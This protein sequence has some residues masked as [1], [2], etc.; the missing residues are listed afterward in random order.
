MIAIKRILAL[1]DCSEPSSDALLYAMEIAKNFKADLIVLKVFSTP[2]ETIQDG[3]VIRDYNVDKKRPEQVREIEDFWNRFAENGIKPE[4]VNL[5]G[6]PFDKIIEYSQKHSIDMIVMGTHG[7]T[8]FKHIF[9]GSVAEKVV[10]YSS[11]P[12]LTVKQKDFEYRQA[13]NLKSV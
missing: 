7:R 11:I 5:L 12:V 4:F 2:V 8:G 10:R 6:D 1:T 9:M 13:D 3:M